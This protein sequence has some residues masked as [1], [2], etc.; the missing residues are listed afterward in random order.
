MLP[1][2]L[3][4]NKYLFALLKLLNQKLKTEIKN[5]NDEST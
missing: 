2:Q 3:T 1:W 5:T 4:E